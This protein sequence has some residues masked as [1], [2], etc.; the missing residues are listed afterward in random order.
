MYD[1]QSILL[2]FSSLS[3][4]VDS[5]NLWRIIFEFTVNMMI[6]FS[7]ARELTRKID[8]QSNSGEVQTEDI[9]NPC[10]VITY[11]LISYMYNV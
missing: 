6:F 7:L 10:I 1:I 8:R 2:G 11:A 4:I 9:H 5:V 3:L